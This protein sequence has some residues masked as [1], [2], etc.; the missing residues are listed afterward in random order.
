MPLGR[1]RFAPSPTGDL[2]LGSLV[3][4]LASSLDARHRGIDWVL[5]LE[6]IDEARAVPGAAGRIFSTLKLLGFLWPEPVLVQSKNLQAYEN[7][8]DSLQ[9][10]GRLFVCHCG[11][12]DYQGAYP[13]T[14]RHLGRLQATDARPKSGVAIRLDTSNSGTLRWQDDWQG[15]QEQALEHEVGDF[16]VRRKDGFH[17]YQLAVVVDDAAQGVTRVVRGMDLLDNTPRQLFLQR[18][19]GLPE[20]EYA[21]LPLVVAPDGTKLSKSRSSAAVAELAPISALR[22]ALKLLR[23]PEPPP[24]LDTV[25]DLHAWAATH[26]NPA[27]LS[28]VANLH[29][30]RVELAGM[31]KLQLP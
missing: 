16:V 26:W 5:R 17:A 4:A 14:C 6:D 1:G 20:P 3:A 9:V 22:L 23:Q 29:V 28:G 15:S 18:L 8:M 11:R 25:H 24:I 21:H 30:P 12:G 19:L 10:Q 13:G 7:A 27:A 31:V 2:H